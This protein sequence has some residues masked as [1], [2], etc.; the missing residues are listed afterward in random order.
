MLTPR[1]ALELNYSWAQNSDV[2]HA[3]AAGVPN[4]R[5]HARQQ[6]ISGA[7]VYS[8]TFKRYNPFVEGGIGAMIF[9]P[10]LD[11]GTNQL[12]VKSNTNPGALFGAGLAYEINP[13]IDIRA[14]YRGFLMKTPGF[15]VEA[16]NTTRYYVLMTPSIGV[17]YH[18]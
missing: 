14:G 7:Y 1:S 18:F 12:S 6:E 3:V 10:L 4:G 15:G 11:N 9:T 13:S 8:R 2:F 17:A 5:V 16:F